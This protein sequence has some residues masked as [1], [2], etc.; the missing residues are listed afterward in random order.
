VRSHRP[1]FGPV[2]PFSISQVRPGLSTMKRQLAYVLGAGAAL[3]AVTVWMLYPRPPQPGTEDYHFMHCPK[4]GTE[5][6]YNPK[7]AGQPCSHCAPGRHLLVPTVDS[8]GRTGGP[9]SPF[10]RMIVPLLLEVTL[11][12]AAIV[13]LSRRPHGSGPEEEYLH[14]RCV[15]QRKLRY[16]SRSAGRQGRCPGCKRSLV[17]PATSADEED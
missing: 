10:A 4:C 14:V 9:P 17:F 13:Y 5:F 2:R 6:A 1:W 7:L 8:V 3:I 16:P 12:L 11:L 15:C